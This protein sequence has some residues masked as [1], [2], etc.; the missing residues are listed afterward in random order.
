VFMD[1][2]SLGCFWPIPF[3]TDVEVEFMVIFRCTYSNDCFQVRGLGK[4]SSI[5]MFAACL[6]SS[7]NVESSTF[8]I[9]ASSL[10]RKDFQPAGVFEDAEIVLV[11][12]PCISNL[13]CSV[14]NSVCLNC[15]LVEKQ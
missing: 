9:L 12:I 3:H 6:M 4:D 8:A 14:V 5:G 15:S 2:C 13:N 1:E 7:M 11:F 10:V